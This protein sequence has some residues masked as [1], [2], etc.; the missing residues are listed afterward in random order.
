LNGLTDLMYV[1]EFVERCSANLVRNKPKK[2]F[3][4]HLR[5][6]LKR[7]IKGPRTGTIKR[8]NLDEFVKCLLFYDESE[9]AARFPEFDF[10]HLLEFT[11]G[12]EKLSVKMAFLCL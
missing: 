7:K 4:M 5:G 8:W 12:Q 2:L 11:E 9:I 1:T 3:R 10:I 6:T